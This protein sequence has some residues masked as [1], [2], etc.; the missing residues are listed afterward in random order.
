MYS[1][2]FIVHR[3]SPIQWKSTVYVLVAQGFA[4]Q[5]YYSLIFAKASDYID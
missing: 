5:E 3:H 2:R 4:F 1:V